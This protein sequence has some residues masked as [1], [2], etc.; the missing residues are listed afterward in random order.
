M[1][2]SNSNVI[3]FP[4]PVAG[5]G[6]IEPQ[7]TPGGAALPSFDALSEEERAAYV[8]PIVRAAIG[9]AKRKGRRLDSLPPQLRVWLLALCDL[10]DPT[11]LS[12][13]AWLDGNPTIIDERTEEDRV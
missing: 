3:A 13:R 5:Q 7:P 9:F 6:L 1:T 12:V 2:P 10:G 11:A 8:A 4:G